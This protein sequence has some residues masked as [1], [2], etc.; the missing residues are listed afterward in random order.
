MLG[1]GS[2]GLRGGELKI[3]LSGRGTSNRKRWPSSSTS[4]LVQW[5]EP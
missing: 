4:P 5:E 1:A 3:S 2:A